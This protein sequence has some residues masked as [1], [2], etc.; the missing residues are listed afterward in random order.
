MTDRT[1]YKCNQCNKLY[2]SYKSRWL[3]IK[4]FHPDNYPQI[5]SNILNLSSEN[6]QNSSIFECN[7]CKKILSR[8]DN[9]KRHKL[10][11]K[12]EDPKLYKLE[13]EVKELKTL[14]Q[15]AMKIHPKTLQK[16]NNQLNNSSVVNG[17][18]INTINIVPLGNENLSELL[19]DNEKLSILNKKYNSIN[20]LINKIHILPD[21]KYRQFKNAYITNLQNDIAYEYDLKS[22]QF[23]AVDKNDLLEK[24]IDKR[25]N[26]IETFAFDL[27]KKN[28]LPHDLSPIIE[29]FI[30]Q[31]WTDESELKQKKIK[32][33]KLL[34]YNNK[35]M[36]RNELKDDFIDE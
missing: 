2:S 7:Y 27:D 13:N 33:V 21:D 11:C 8:S 19:S 35:D 1:E 24:L 29:K 34:L 5:S 18:V 20:E 23:V 31:M 16:I 28:N 15:K 12:K 36:I 22:K 26:D 9:L 10:K 25:M 14:L 6:P 32:Q 4:K 30:E 17:N 3:H